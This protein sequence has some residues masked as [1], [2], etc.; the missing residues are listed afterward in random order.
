[1]YLVRKEHSV[2]KGC[3]LNK[4]VKPTELAYEKGFRVWLNVLI[5]IQHPCPR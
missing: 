5:T 1:M 2:L 4:Q 3:G